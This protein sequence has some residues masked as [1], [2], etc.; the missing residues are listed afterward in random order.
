VENYPAINMHKTIAKEQLKYI[1]ENSPNLTEAT[2]QVYLE[3]LARPQKMHPEFFSEQNFRVLSSVS[4]RLIPQEELMDKVDLPGLLDASM[5]SGE[6]DGWRY[7]EMPDDKTALQSGLE[8]IDAGS[9]QLY[10]VN[11]TA[12]AP[13]QKDALLTSVQSGEINW[14]NLN[15]ARFFEELLARLTEIYYSHP[16]T[17]M[18]INDQSGFDLPGWNDIGLSQT[19][20]EDR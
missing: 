10:G 2:R 19:D 14:Q 18:S 6:G 15:A 16:I 13:K 7:S 20:R 1:V 3:R 5:A 17:R 4:E 11:F 12:L 8:Q 9:Q